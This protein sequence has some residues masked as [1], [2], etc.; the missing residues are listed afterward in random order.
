MNI[1]ILI[2]GKGSNML[3]IVHA[4]RNK[5]IDANV[6]IVISNKFT[7]GIIKA[8]KLGVLTKVVDSKKFVSKDLFEKKISFLFKKHKVSLICLA[9]YM[10]ILGKNF[11]KEWEKKIINIHPSLLPSFKGVNAQSQAIQKGV[12]YSG[13]TIHYVSEKLDDGEILDQKVVKI[14]NSENAKTLSKKI[15]IE[16]HKL[17]IKV[18]KK[19]TKRRSYE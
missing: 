13:C 17:Y 10:K 7:E 18:L 8:N 6:E 4:C 9:G 12:K 1:G 2:S 19:L 11:V 14:S 16:E 5:I 15:L 3:N